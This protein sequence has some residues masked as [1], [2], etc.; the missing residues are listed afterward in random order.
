[1]ID[2]IIVGK[3]LVP[4]EELGVLPSEQTLIIEDEKFLPR[5]LVKVGIAKSTSQVKQIN[6]Q[7]MKSN[8]IKDP[9]E[10]NL[11]RELNDPEFTSFKIGKHVF[12]LIVGK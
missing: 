9:L 2:N 10:K 1:M 12:W 4:L 3:P 7:R 6:Q 5:L 11:W 8:K